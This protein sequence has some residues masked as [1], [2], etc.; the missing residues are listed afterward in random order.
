RDGAAAGL[1]AMLPAQGLGS[2]TLNGAPVA[3][4]TQTVKGVQYAVFPAASGNYVAAYSSGPAAAHVASSFTGTL[5]D[6]KRTSGACEDAGVPGATPP[7]PGNGGNGNGGNSGGTGNNGNSG[8]TGN[9]GGS[10]TGT[11]TVITEAGPLKATA[12]DKASTKG[13][14]KTTPFVSAS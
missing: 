10:G 7:P 4:D 5:P 12:T 6:G 9:G 2:V 8:T 1:Q 11:H 14:P 3:Y 13:K